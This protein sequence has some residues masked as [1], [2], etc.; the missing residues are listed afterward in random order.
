MLLI[1]QKYFSKFLPKFWKLLR[2]SLVFKKQFF[3]ISH[4]KDHCRKRSNNLFFSFKIVL[5]TV[6]ICRDTLK[7]QTFYNV[8]KVNNN[9]SRIM[10]LMFLV[11]FFLTLNIFISLI[12][13][14]MVNFEHAL[15]Y[16]KWPS[17]TWY[18]NPLTTN[19]PHHIETSQLICN[20][21]QLTGFYV[22]ESLIG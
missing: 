13:C 17:F 16:L 11:F 12:K 3:V 20:T 1:I 8:S 18:I 21:N 2:L 4:L 6:V 19:I 14:F 7:A 15:A 10:F 9:D 22:M 5:V